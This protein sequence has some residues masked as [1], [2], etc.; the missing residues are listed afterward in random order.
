VRERVARAAEEGVSLA[1]L[2][3]ATAHWHARLEAGHSGSRD[4]T[5]ACYKFD[6]DPGAEGV[7]ATTRWRARPGPDLHE[8]L[9]TGTGLVGRAAKPTDLVVCNSEHWVWTGAGVDDGTAIDGLV[10]GQVDGID[11]AV[12]GPASQPSIVL[13]ASPFVLLGQETTGVQNTAVSEFP[14]GAF[15]FSAGTQEWQHGLIGD[16]ADPRVQAATGNVLRRMSAGPQGAHA[17]TDD[18]LA[19]PTT[20]TSLG[21]IW[22]RVRAR[23]RSRQA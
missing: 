18:G 7:D 10:A 14:G 5:L 23:S 1:F 12:A 21:Q 20:S 3:S 8:Q 6:P 11:A 16:R 15:V 9:L 19:T 17:P 2:G 13:A 4:R 22:A